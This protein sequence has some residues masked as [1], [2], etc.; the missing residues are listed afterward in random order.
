MNKRKGQSREIGANDIRGLLARVIRKKKWYTRLELH[1]VFSFWNE[2][3]GEDIS[4]RAQPACIRGSVLWVDVI[5]PIWMQQL[6]LQ[7]LLLLDL[8]NRRLDNGSISDIRF[9][10]NSELSST[11]TAAPPKKPAR[12]IDKKKLQEFEEQLVPLRDEEVKKALLR[13][14]KKYQTSP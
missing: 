9:K 10:L 7:K 12:P 3:V 13:L 2:V 5:D 6:H 11:K 1:G 14:W 8:I 4:G